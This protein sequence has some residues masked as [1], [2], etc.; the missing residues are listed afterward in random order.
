MGETGGEPAAGEAEQGAVE[1]TQPAGEE[2]ESAGPARAVSVADYT[3]NP[4]EY[5]GDQIE[6]SG[7]V[8]QV[9]GPNAFAIGGDEFVGGQQVI[10]VGA[11]QLNQIVEGE[12]VEITTDQVVQATGTARE[13]N[14]TEIE[15]EV[16]YQLDDNLFSEFEG[17]PALAASSV[18]VQVAGDETTVQSADVSINTIID[19]PA[20]FYNQTVTVSGPVAR[21]LSPTMFVITSQETLN[22]QEDGFFDSPNELAQSG[23]LV[24]TEGGQSVDLTE[25]QTVQVTGQVQQFDMQE[26]EQELGTQFTGDVYTAFSEQPAI[27]AS[28]VQPNPGGETTGQ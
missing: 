7:Q 18:E 25:Q 14:L 22:Q 4:S 27:I 16:G 10:I 28:E 1:E 6:L 5:Y 23:I 13:F 11:Q 3:D 15:N 12:A 19:E 17:N 21:I 9:L 24:T 26:F 20:E 8:T 2:A